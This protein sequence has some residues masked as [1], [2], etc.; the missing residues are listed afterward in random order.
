[1]NSINSS[2]IAASF[3]KEK[4][5]KSVIIPAPTRWSSLVNS[6]ARLIEI[7]DVVNEVCKQCK[8][9]TLSTEDKLKMQGILQLIEPFKLLTDQLQSESTPTFSL[10]YLGILQL[11]EILKVCFSSVY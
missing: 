8:F 1:L 4:S 5:K 2:H 10:I 6:Y 3:I 7:F 11:I 9:D